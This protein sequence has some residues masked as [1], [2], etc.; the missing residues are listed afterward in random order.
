MDLRGKGPNGVGLYS[1]NV[2]GEAGHILQYGCH[3]VNPG[4]TIRSAWT[5]RIKDLSNNTKARSIKENGK[6]IAPPGRKQD[7]ATH[8]GLPLRT[9][10]ERGHSSSIFGRVSCQGSCAI[11]HVAGRKSSTTCRDTEFVCQFVADGLPGTEGGS[12]RIL[13]R[14]P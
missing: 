14:V 10:G 6:G 3:E 5:G 9:W 4:E 8:G 2:R 12:L 1:N 11:T 7:Y 13:R